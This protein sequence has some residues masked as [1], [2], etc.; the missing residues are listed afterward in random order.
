MK[1]KNLLLNENYLNPSLIN[2]IKAIENKTNNREYAKIGGDSAFILGTNKDVK[3]PTKDIKDHTSHIIHSHPKNE[4][5]K[6]SMVSI[7]DLQVAFM[8]SPK[9][10][11][12]INLP[13]IN[14][15]KRI[16]L[17]LKSP[18]IS[19]GQKESLVES[20]KNLND[21]IRLGG[22]AYV[23]SLD[24]LDE[25]EIKDEKTLINYLSGT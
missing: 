23:F 16:N 5:K 22:K 4:P 21:F 24:K 9:M 13:T 18:N 11:Q 7:E 10:D 20:I 12:I 1:L 6:L 2:D 15:E 19:I 25:Q 3:I 8:S 17:K 14:N